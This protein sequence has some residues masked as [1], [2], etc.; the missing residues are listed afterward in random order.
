MFK[1]TIIVQEKDLGVVLKLLETK[2]NVHSQDIQYIPRGNNE[3]DKNT[4]KR[5]LSKQNPTY[6]YD[7]LAR[8]EELVL[9]LFKDRAN[10]ILDKQVV[11]KYLAQNGYAETSASPIMS[12][13]TKIGLIIRINHGK[14]MYKDHVNT[15]DTPVSDKKSYIPFTT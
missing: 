15:T 1:I 7:H 14:Y 13:L 8:S 11:A 3:V 5:N 12:T 2:V 9:A 10:E 6:L 4:P